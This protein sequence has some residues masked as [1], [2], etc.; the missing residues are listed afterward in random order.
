MTSNER[1]M[2]WDGTPAPGPGYR[3]PGGGLSSRGPQASAREVEPFTSSHHLR[4]G[5]RVIGS[6]LALLPLVVAFLLLLR[7]WRSGLTVGSV[8]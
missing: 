3:A 6:L 1:S 7:F 8:K 5:L 4:R 2:P